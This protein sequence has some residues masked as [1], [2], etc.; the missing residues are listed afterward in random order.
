MTILT[1]QNPVRQAST[2]E[3]RVPVLRKSAAARSSDQAVADPD[4]VDTLLLPANLIG[5]DE[6][7]IFVVKPALWFVLFDCTNWAIAALCLIGCASWFADLLHMAES[8]FMTV[9]LTLFAV[10]VGLALLRW[11]SRFYVLTNRRIM[12]I[13]G[14]IKPDVFECSLVNIRNTSVTTSFPEALTKLGTI[15]FIST[16][17][18]YPDGCW[19]NLNNPHQVHEEIRRAIRRSLDCQPHL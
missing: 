13:R 9:V 11:V 7:I 16:E 18:Q 2:V 1:P 5:G 10:R 19:K 15:N 12:R 8:R 17:S 3:Q 14:V 6:S 4:V